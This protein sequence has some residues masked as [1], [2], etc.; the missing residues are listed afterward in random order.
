M[1]AKDQEIHQLRAELGQK[2]SQ[3]ARYRGQPP[4]TAECRTGSGAGAGA[5]FG[6]GGGGGGGGGSGTSSS[7]GS[8]E[9]M[10]RERLGAVGAPRAPAP[11]S[12]AAPAA[13]FSADGQGAADAAAA[14]VQVFKERLIRKAVGI[15]A[16]E[17]RSRDSEVTQLQ[18]RL[19][20]AAAAI[21]SPPSLTGTAAAPM[22]T[23]GRVEQGGGEEGEVATAAAALEGA[24]AEVERLGGLL[25][26]SEE[27]REAEAALYQDARAALERARAEAA[28]ARARC[29]ALEA[30]LRAAREGAA[31]AAAE[32]ASSAAAARP[33]PAQV[34]RVSE[35]EARAA[36]VTELEA[37]LAAAAAA[38]EGERREGEALRRKVEDLTAQMEELAAKSGELG[39]K[40]KQ[41][42]SRV[43]RDD[44]LMDRWILVENRIAMTVGHHLS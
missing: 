43:S 42:K 22:P 41:A 5:G 19:A 2:A 44:E 28:A 37:R 10:V 18:E 3:A 36:R 8:I 6:S 29:D 24:R 15:I 27:Q 9:S 20:A 38:G 32:A 33:D 12:G 34:A 25:R 7:A 11:E 21:A 39:E 35:L 1:E 13:F 17:L 4:A 30:E 40:L 31:A 26:D 16:S 14:D 23:V